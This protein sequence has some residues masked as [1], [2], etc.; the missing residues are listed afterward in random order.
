MQQWCLISGQTVKTNSALDWLKIWPSM[1]GA[2]HDQGANTLHCHCP[3][4][5]LLIGIEE[6]L[7]F[8]DTLPPDEAVFKMI[9]QAA[10]FM[11]STSTNVMTGESWMFDAMYKTAYHEIWCKRFTDDEDYKQKYII[12][13]GNE[14]GEVTQEQA[15]Q[16]IKAYFS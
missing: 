5:E 15:S 6:P 13:F 16:Q 12:I 2:F 14:P 8:D 11:L 1:V 9:R 3:P 7:V 4:S 10:T